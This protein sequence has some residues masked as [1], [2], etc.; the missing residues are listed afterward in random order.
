MNPDATRKRRTQAEIQEL[1]NEF[2]SSGMRRSEFCRLHGLSF[3]TLQRYLNRQGEK[4]NALVART[5]LLPVQLTNPRH[6]SFSLDSGLAVAL[7]SGA[8]IEVARGFDPSTLERLLS[9]LERR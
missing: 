2:L 8:K 6:S 5:Q 9:V 4:P 7:A 3:G 1:I